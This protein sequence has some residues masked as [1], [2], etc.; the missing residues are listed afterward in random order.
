MPKKMLATALLSAAL[1]PSALA[2]E[3][4]FAPDARFP[5]GD[6]VRELLAEGVK[7]YY[8]GRFGNAA[9]RFHDALKQN[10]DNKLCYEFYLAAGDGLLVAMEEHDELR[11]V[12]KDLLRQARIY[13]KD[14]RRDPKYL[15]LLVDKLEKSEEERLVATNEL[16]AVGPIAVPTL[17]ARM[18]DNR[19][20]DM[21]VYCRIVLTRMGYR[22]VIPLAE[23]L[24]AADERL[25]ASVATV[26][27]DIGDPRPLPKLKQF[28]SDLDWVDVNLYELRR[29]DVPGIARKPGGRR[30][31]IEACTEIEEHIAAAR[32]FICWI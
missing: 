22:A 1:I 27:A 2:A 17:V 16:V 14:L 9:K 3:E 31:I 15:N 6:Q 7:E 30:A 24:N 21:R 8:A 23:A 18:N 26:L 4:G 12:L 29:W 25:V 10:P 32:R 28:A 5:N 19:Q 20:D 11:E 13:Q